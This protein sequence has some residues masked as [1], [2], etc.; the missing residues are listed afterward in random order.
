MPITEM[1]SIRQCEKSEIQQKLALVDWKFRFRIL[2]QSAFF[3]KN[4][5]SLVS[6]R[7]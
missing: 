5:D 6:G 2:D 7:G 3:Y 1:S 4:F